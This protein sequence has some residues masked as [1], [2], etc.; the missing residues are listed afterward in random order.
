MLNDESEA[1]KKDG[2]SETI[3]E[4]LM[5]MVM[6]QSHELVVCTVLGPEKH[7]KDFIKEVTALA[8]H[9]GCDVELEKV[10]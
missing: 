4:N 7:V 10:N 8:E 2:G 1:S 3:N 5:N 9:E 6:V